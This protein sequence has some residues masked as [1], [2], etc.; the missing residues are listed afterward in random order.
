MQKPVVARV[1]V[2]KERHGGDPLNA[3]KPQIEPDIEG[4]PI[5]FVHYLVDV[6]SV[7]LYR[8]NLPN[9]QFSIDVPGHSCS[10][11][12]NVDIH[13]EWF[14]AGAFRGG[15]FMGP[16]RKRISKG[17]TKTRVLVLSYG[18]SGAWVPDVK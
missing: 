9:R 8:G 5:R 7:D 17:L 6:E 14:I 12:T 4:G 11:G 13:S 16:G 15:F 18:M 10:I 2:L 3:G 1:R